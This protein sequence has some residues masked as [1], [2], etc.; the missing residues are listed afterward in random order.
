[1]A[2]GDRGR[3]VTSEHGTVMAM[4]DSDLTVRC[5]DGGTEVLTGEE[6]G[7]DCLDHAYAF[8]VHRMRGATVDRAHVFGDGGGRELAYVA[9][10]RSRDASHV[11][12]VPDDAA[13][14]VDDLRVEWSARGVNNG[15]S[16]MSTSPPMVTHVGAEILP[17]GWTRP[18]VTPGSRSSAQPLSL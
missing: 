7:S 1:M 10:S 6:H 16:P 11:V 13:Q 17:D 15:L 4:G 14:T 2:P 9:M 5:D 3:F 8:T 18:S 12:V